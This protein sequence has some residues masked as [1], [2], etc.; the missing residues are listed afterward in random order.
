MK[1]HYS[2]LLGILL[3]LA[4]FISTPAFAHSGRTDSSGGHRDNKNK[5]GLGSY[6]YHCGGHPA[7]LHSNGI[8]P[9]DPKD[10][11]SISNA[12]SK[13]YL[14]DSKQLS[15]TVTAYSGSTYVEWES[16]NESVVKISS[17]GLLT[18]VGPGN[19]KITATLR[20]GSK[21]FNISVTTRAVE[22]IALIATD[23]EPQIGDVLKLTAEVS[24]ANATEKTVSWLSDNEDVAIVTSDGIVIVIGEGIAKIT[25]TACDGSNKKGTLTLSSSTNDDDQIDP[26]MIMNQLPKNYVFTVKPGSTA[27]TFIKR[28]E[29]PFKYAVPLDLPLQ[30]GSRGETVKDIQAA[31]V[32]TGHLNDKIDGIF[33]KNTDS[34]VASFCAF[35]N[36][37]YNGTVDFNLYVS[38]MESVHTEIVNPIP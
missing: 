32:S 36:I 18:A 21:S 25:A 29:L 16:S 9:Y 8:C 6:H 17:S 23:S 27:S 2:R 37:K 20:N 7:H 24:P 34:G 31:L 14:G 30:I 15:W 35:H 11:I 5:S 28:Y 38:I 22:K 13:M 26:L 19:A 3:A 10:S 12:P 1:K 33:G 4:L